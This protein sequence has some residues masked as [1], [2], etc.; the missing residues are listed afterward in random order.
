MISTAINTTITRLT[1]ISSVLTWQSVRMATH[2]LHWLRKTVWTLVKTTYIYKVKLAIVVEGGPKVSFLIVTIP[3]FKRRSQ[4]LSVDFSALPVAYNAVE[5]SRNIFWVYGM[6][7][8]EEYTLVPGTIS[9]HSTLRPTDRY[10]RLIKSFKC[11][12]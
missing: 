6:I 8:P 2:H 5:V 3:R 9:E 12:N 1:F 4:L 10:S 7:W 11:Y